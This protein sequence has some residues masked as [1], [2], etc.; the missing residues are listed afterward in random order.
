LG[1]NVNSESVSHLQT[2]ASAGSIV[3]PDATILPTAPS[4]AA[5]PENSTRSGSILA[6]GF[7]GVG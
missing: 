6:S 2:P 7:N 3:I 5:E 1:V 4:R